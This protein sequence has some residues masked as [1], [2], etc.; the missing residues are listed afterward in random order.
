M[1]AS[2]R[3][4]ECGAQR[5]FQSHSPVGIVPAL[6][7]PREKLALS[8][9]TSPLF[10]SKI[11]WAVSIPKEMFSLDRRESDAGR[12]ATSAKIRE[13]FIDRSCT[14]LV[15]SP[16]S[17]ATTHVASSHPRCNVTVRENCVNAADHPI[18][19]TPATSFEF[20]A[21][22]AMPLSHRKD[23]RLGILDGR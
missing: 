3:R 2:R 8:W 6:F 19:G 13:I 7:F 14:H 9:N 15:S 18:N 17:G 21:R 22:L 10:R 5:R 11:A 1:A 16:R 12:L 20:V 23:S 4:A